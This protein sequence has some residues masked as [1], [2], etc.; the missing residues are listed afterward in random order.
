MTD[1]HAD[2]PAD[3]D[4][5]AFLCRAFDV[6]TDAVAPH[7]ATVTVGPRVRTALRDTEGRTR[8]TKPNL[9]VVSGALPEGH[10]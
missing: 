9:R 3:A 8:S 10:P 4:M 2:S 1:N 6:L 7:G 5:S